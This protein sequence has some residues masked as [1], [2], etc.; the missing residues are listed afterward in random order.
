MQ[1]VKW[2]TIKMYTTYCITNNQFGKDL[3]KKQQNDGYYHSQKYNRT[4]IQPQI[5]TY[6][7]FGIRI[8]YEK[9]I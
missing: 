2:N 7:K 6:G 4:N 8:T 1:D 9:K 3:E 5:Y